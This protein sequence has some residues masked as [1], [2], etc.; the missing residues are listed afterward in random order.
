MTKKI[1]GFETYWAYIPHPPI[2]KPTTWEDPSVTVYTNATWW[3]G[4]IHNAH[5]KFAQ[6]ILNF[7]AYSKPVPLCITKSNETEPC[8]KIQPEQKFTGW[9]KQNN[10]FI[11]WKMFGW[12]VVR[13]TNNYNSAGNRYNGTTPPDLPECWGFEKYIMN[14]PSWTLCRLNNASKITQGNYTW[15]DWSPYASN[16]GTGDYN[17]NLVPP[18]YTS[19]NSSGIF[20]QLEVWK[21][22]LSMGGQT[23]F[24]LFTPLENRTTF[25]VACL[26]LPWGILV[27]NFTV[28]YE[29][30][31]WKIECVSCAITNCINHTVT[32]IL[33][34]HQ[35]KHVLLPVH[36]S[37]PWYSDP[38]LQ[39]W[40]KLLEKHRIRKKRVA[41]WVIFGIIT[42]ITMIVSVATAGIALHQEIYTAQEVDNLTKNIT[43]ALDI[44]EDIDEKIDSRLNILHDAL[45]LLGDSIDNLWAFVQLKC[46]Y[47]YRSICVTNLK[48]NQTSTP[49][50]L[51]K[52]HLQTSW[53]NTNYTMDITLLKQKIHEL[54]HAPSALEAE[55][56]EQLLTDLSASLSL[57]KPILIGLLSALV[58]IL[59]CF[60]ILYCLCRIW[61]SQ[62]HSQAVVRGLVL[63]GKDNNP[64]AGIWLSMIDR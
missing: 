16:D 21:L 15:L 38:A 41:D 42:L 23:R 33:I 25:P 14:N 10:T 55:G 54:R 29:N 6:Q 60:F 39:I 34:V 13:P 63:Q 61:R 9:S 11:A 20:P 26:P 7:T 44:Q 58:P 49:W 1:T 12:G 35:P 59:L 36:I 48:Y 37:Q 50:N 19:L 24:E 3:L 22:M 52:Q 45:V 40:H 53:R 64:A 27:D 32:K 62:Y 56:F 46:H 51:V 31:T 57:T 28:H 8:L 30:D 17:R 47:E 4:G 18:I 43:Q 2:L 5:M